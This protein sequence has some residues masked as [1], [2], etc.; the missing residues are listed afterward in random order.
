MTRLVLLL[1]CVGWALVGGFGSW[2]YAH[3]YY[4]Y[5]GFPRPSEVA[6]IPRGRLVHVRFFSP[7]LGARRYYFAYLPPGYAAAARRGER[8]PVLYLLHAPPGRPENYVLVGAMDVRYDELLAQR[9]IQPFIVVL[10]NG[11]T[12]AFGS[13]TEWANARAGRYEDFILDT[14]RSVDH[15]FA[16]LHARR[17]RVLGGLSEGGYGAANVA[18]HNPG[19][20]GGFESWSGYF[21]QTPTFAFS[22]ASAAELRR[23]S[24]LHEARAFGRRFRHMRVDL[25]QGA[26]DDVPVNGMLAFAQALRADGATVRTAVY[27]GGHNWRLWRAHFGQMLRWTSSTLGGPR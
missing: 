12:H 23:N 18:L 3:D 9:R 25:Y 1:L 14:V 5:R 22:G 20:F 6:G 2:S 13:D 24:P 27:Q 17:G 15:R 21:T 11:R 16:T 26:T 4:V 7:A 8:F 19:V 10:P